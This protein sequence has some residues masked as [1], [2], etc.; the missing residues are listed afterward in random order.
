M[1]ERHSRMPPT[2]YL[3]VLRKLAIDV[4]S[5]SLGPTEPRPRGKT[6]R[7]LLWSSAWPQDEPVG[8]MWRA[9]VARGD[10][11]RPQI[12]PDASQ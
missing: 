6:C 2:T 3:H 1:P 10:L 8:H 4:Q 11:V 7:L 9:S 12:S 5:L